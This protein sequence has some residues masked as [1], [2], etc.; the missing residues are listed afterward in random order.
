VEELPAAIQSTSAGEPLV[1]ALADADEESPHHT[2]AA[3][4]VDPSSVNA[5][6]SSSKDTTRATL[7]PLPEQELG[8]ARGVPSSADG[9]GFSILATVEVQLV[10]R[11]LDVASR[12]KAARCN[13]QL[14]AAASQ[15][16]AWPKEQMVPL[17]VMND[18]DELQALGQRV[19]RSLM[20]MV[21]IELHVQVREHEPLSDIFAVTNV[22]ALKLDLA[23]VQ[24]TL[25][26]A[27]SGVLESLLS[28]PA[29]QHLRSLD[30]ARLLNS[31]CSST[32]AQLI[33]T[34][35]H[36]HSLTGQCPRRL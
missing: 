5:A 32:E 27:H 34:L 29:A 7:A 31:R 10:L 4:V 21:P 9:S 15:P 13:K 17:S 18:G 24:N 6:T 20:R 26:V 8:R 14:L 23:N 36:L 22:H 19:P 30:I 28:H 12:L 16:F 1:A 11:L 25:C 2:T 3:V 35:P 33:G